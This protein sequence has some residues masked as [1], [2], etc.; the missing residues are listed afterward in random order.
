M[1][2]LEFAAMLKTEQSRR[3][4]MELIIEDI[5]ANGPIRLALL[6][7]QPEKAEEKAPAKDA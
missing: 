6:G 4:I 1:N 7:L 2:N 5:R 3:A